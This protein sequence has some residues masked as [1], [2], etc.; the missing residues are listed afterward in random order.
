[1]EKVITLDPEDFSNAAALAEV[2]K[3]EGNRQEGD[4]VINDYL[5]R[6]PESSEAY[7]RKIDPLMRKDPKAAKEILQQAIKKHPKNGTFVFNL[8]VLLQDER[9]IKEAA[10]HFVKAADLDK[11]S[12]HIQGWTGRFFLKVQEDKP[13]ALRY[14]LN[15]YFLDP[16]YRDTEYAES[17]IRR[18]GFE[19]AQDRLNKVKKEGKKLPELLWDDDPFF[20]GM[21]IDGMG[22]NWQKEYVKPLL[23]SLE[24]DDDTVRAKI[25]RALQDNVDKSFDEELA[26]WL[27]DPDLRKRGMAGY[28]AVKLWGEKGIKEV[29]PWFDDKAQILRYDAVFSVWAHGGEEGRKMVL[30]RLAKERHPWFKEVYKSLEKQKNTKNHFDWN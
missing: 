16:H 21:V 19:A 30:E 11:E 6:F 14:Y 5:K 7:N 10:E 22:K 13:K 26:K 20:V 23:Q 4:Q 15:A 29:S 25:N 12:T 18:L 2:L 27:K 8:G 9:N 1:L 24:N 3:R 17:R 28:L